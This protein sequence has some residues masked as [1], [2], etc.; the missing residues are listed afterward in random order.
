MNV[1]DAGPLSGRTS[2][3]GHNC[4]VSREC[5]RV[6]HAAGRMPRLVGLESATDELLW[7]STG[8]TRAGGDRTPTAGCRCSTVGGISSC[9]GRPHLHGE[10][11]ALPQ[12]RGPG[13]RIA[14]SVEPMRRVSPRLLL[15]V[16][17]GATDH[18]I[19]SA[20]NRHEL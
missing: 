16:Q 15:S 14:V 12:C 6:F 5:R 10:L 9:L 18:Q 2:A 4:T 1:V 17:H 8:S 11:I 20:E 13:G 19:P 3:A 7:G